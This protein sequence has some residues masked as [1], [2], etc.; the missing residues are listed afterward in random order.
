M[1]LVAVLAGN[2][3]TAYKNH[4]KKV[5]AK[6]DER[7]RELNSASL[8]TARK[9]EFEIARAQIFASNSN[10]FDTKM[11]LDL[12]KVDNSATIGL[13]SRTETL[14][15]TPAHNQDKVAENLT[16]TNLIVR[17][18]EQ[19]R[20]EVRQTQEENWAVKKDKLEQ[21]L[22]DYGEKYEQERNEKI[23]FWF[24]WIGIPVILIGG[25]IAAC[26]FFPPLAGI[27]VSIFPKLVS[28]FGVVG[29]STVKNVVKGVGDVRNSLKIQAD[30]NNVLKEKGHE[31][32]TYTPE[33][34]LE[35]IDTSLKIHTD[36][37]DK[38]VIDHIRKKVNT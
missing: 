25:L 11:S 10:W 36:L 15:G 35:M 1:V 32:E 16:S 29:A 20:Q 28:L 12:A 33:E 31:P 17:Q 22:I 30:Q 19:S 21:K 38:E 13:L 4:L 5:D 8:Y 34:V 3:C 7:V 14:I 2:G 9:T 6:I 26:V 37:K 18:A 23:K 24:K 27:V